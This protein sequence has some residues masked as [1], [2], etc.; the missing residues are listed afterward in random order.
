MPEDNVRQIHEIL[1]AQ[2]LDADNP[3]MYR[4]CLAVSTHA[5]PH[6]TPLCLQ[7]R[8][9]ALMKLIGIVCLSAICL[10]GLVFL[11]S[12]AGSFS[13]FHAPER[14]CTGTGACCKFGN[15]DCP[16]SVVEF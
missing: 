15:V 1:L 12:M 11:I 7:A 4:E 13:Y 8:Q 14:C 5:L 9:W 16:L 2:R 10:N 3:V 6:P